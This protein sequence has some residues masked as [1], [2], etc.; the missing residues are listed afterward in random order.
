MKYSG[1]RVDGTNVQVVWLI[2]RTPIQST[3]RSAS[4][5]YSETC[6]Y[7]LCKYP[8]TSRNA[9]VQV[10]LISHLLGS[11]RVKRTIIFTS[12]Y[13][14]IRLDTGSSFNWISYISVPQ[15]DFP[16]FPRIQYD[17]VEGP[18]RDVRTCGEE[19]EALWSVRVGGPVDS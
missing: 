19:G 16:G 10:Y 2:Y 18:F 17:P 12:L 11:L 8:G 14:E 3:S 1:V 15:S 6:K 4:A 9:G 13:P 5:I 7:G